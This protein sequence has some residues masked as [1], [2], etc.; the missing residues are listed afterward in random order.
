M[1][2]LIAF[3]MFVILVFTLCPLAFGEAKG[4]PED[5]YSEIVKYF[6][7]ET[8]KSS[9]ERSIL[10]EQWGS[11]LM[12]DM[13]LLIQWS[14]DKTGFWIVYNRPDRPRLT[15]VWQILYPRE[16]D[17]KNIFRIM[18]NYAVGYGIDEDRC[19]YFDTKGGHTHLF[20][21][22]DTIEEKFKDYYEFNDIDK[23][24]RFIIKEYHPK[25]SDWYDKEF[26]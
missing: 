19:W 20:H 12:E 16:T 23:F 15:Q 18:H 14:D 13:L 25:F 2:K 11:G 9:A 17:Y 3:T 26:S 8:S 21:T 22:V 7:Q 10:A 1:K 4:T 24:L 5:V 6:G